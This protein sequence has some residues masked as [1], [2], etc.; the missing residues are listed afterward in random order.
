MDEDT[1]ILQADWTRS[2]GTDVYVRLYVPICMQTSFHKTLHWIVAA[3]KL[4]VDRAVLVAF[5]EYGHGSYV[6]N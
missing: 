3:D 1:L 5:T 2:L 6:D 4:M